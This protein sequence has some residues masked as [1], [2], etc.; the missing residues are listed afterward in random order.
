[1]LLWCGGFLSFA[2]KKLIE[3]SEALFTHYKNNPIIPER[4]TEITNIYKEIE[5]YQLLVWKMSLDTGFPIIFMIP[6]SC[7]YDNVNLQ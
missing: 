7:D 3:K 5:V 6:L 2:L 1:M 4:K